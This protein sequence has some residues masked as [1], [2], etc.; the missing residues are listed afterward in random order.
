MII[1]FD[2]AAIYNRSTDILN[3]KENDLLIIPT[4]YYG[5]SKYVIY[6]RSLNYKYFG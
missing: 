5:F 6:Q 3:R 4:D 2:S 1:N